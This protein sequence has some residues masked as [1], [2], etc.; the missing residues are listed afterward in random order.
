MTTPA[1]LIAIEDAWVAEPIVEQ[2]LGSN[3]TRLG[4]E[5]GF[6]RV[7]WCAIA[8]TLA[9]GQAFGRE[10]FRSAAVVQWIDAARAGVGGMELLDDVANTWIE[11]GMLV[12][13]DF[14]GRGNPA[15]FH[16]AFVRDGGSQAKFQTDAGNEGD[17]MR[18]GWRDRKY[19]TH[20]IRLP[21]DAA[22]TPGDDD[23]NRYVAQTRDHADAKAQGGPARKWFFWRGD[24]QAM[25]AAVPAIG[26]SNIEIGGL[27]LSIGQA[28]TEADG[29]IVVSGT[30]VDGN[31]YQALIYTDG[32]TAHPAGTAPVIDPLP[33]ATG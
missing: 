28:V 22:S 18:Q 6:D 29:V 17:A 10:L 26:E 27:W 21:Y 12:T 16:I 1:D 19:V 4:V 23:M 13:Y 24:D 33:F 7:A 9:I 14:G 32:N 25:H 11:P 8:Q 2:P 30:G 15:D 20:F 3:H 5:F 31:A